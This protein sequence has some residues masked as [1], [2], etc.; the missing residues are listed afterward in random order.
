M[1]CF[2]KLLKR[3][4]ETES[5]ATQLLKLGKLQQ[6]YPLEFFKVIVL[7]CSTKGTM[8]G[9]FRRVPGSWSFTIKKLATQKDLTLSRRRP[10]SY[11]NQSIDLLCLLFKQIVVSTNKIN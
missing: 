5:P 2:S 8:T 11:R 10:I 6:I 7:S 9:T 3:T 4:T 1:K